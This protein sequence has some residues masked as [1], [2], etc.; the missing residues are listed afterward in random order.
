MPEV[1]LEEEKVP[2]AKTVE[3]IKEKL[4][5]AECFKDLPISDK[6]K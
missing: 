1:S 4:M 2:E 6:L 3:E 5:T